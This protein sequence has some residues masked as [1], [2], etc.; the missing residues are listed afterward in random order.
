ME[1]EERHWRS[2]WLQACAVYEARSVGEAGPV[3]RLATEATDP[4]LRETLEW[5]AGRAE[6]I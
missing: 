4:V 2:P 5:A 1:D 6:T 3:R